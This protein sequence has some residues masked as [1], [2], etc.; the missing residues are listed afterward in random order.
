MYKLTIDFFNRD[1]V[2]QIAK[3]LIGKIL[4]TN[5]NVV[6]TSGRIVE[7]EAYVGLTDKASHSFAGKPTPRNEHM[8]A[9]AGTA[10]IYVCYGIHQMFN[11][12]TN[13]SGVPDAILVRA[14]DP[15]DGIDF[16]LERTGKL[17]LD[18]S[19]TRGPGNVGKALG[20]NKRYSGY[21]LAGG[22]IFIEDDNI[23]FGV[24]AI[25]SSPRIGVAYAGVDA[26]L[27]YRFYFKGN[28]FVSGKPNN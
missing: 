9:Q 14:L 18:Y 28:R 12:V 26:Q 13:S 27:P 23:K 20:F 16:M 15:L 17:S 11:I 2:V 7:T 24:D 6:R 4:V 19:L 5:F 25:R 3:E 1:N 22:E 8:Y 10:Y 21:S